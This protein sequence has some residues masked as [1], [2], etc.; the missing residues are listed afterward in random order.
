MEIQVDYLTELNSFEE[1]IDKIKKY[2]Y[3]RNNKM[4]VNVFKQFNNIRIDFFEIRE[5]LGLYF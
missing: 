5:K 1:S 2:L 4:D 3:Q